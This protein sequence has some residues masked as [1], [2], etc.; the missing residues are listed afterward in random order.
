[1]IDEGSNV[2]LDSVADRAHLLDPFLEAPRYRRGV[3]EGPVE[4]RFFRGKDRAALVCVGRADRD[5]VVELRPALVEIEDASGSLRRD[6]DPL[7]PEE[8]RERPD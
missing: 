1:V 4:A 8:R 3:R 6:V 2:G 5:D 7:L